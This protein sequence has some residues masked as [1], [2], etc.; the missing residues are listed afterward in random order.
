MIL[1]LINTKVYI[2]FLTLFVLSSIS[3]QNKKI[4]IHSNIDSAYVFINNQFIGYTPLN[5]IILPNDTINLLI[6]DENVLNW[7]TQKIN[8]NIIVNKDTTILIYFKHKLFINTI[9]DNAEIFLN[10]KI[11]GKSPLFILY[12]MSTSNKI[13]I[14]KENFNTVSL[15]TDSIFSKTLLIE[16]Q[17]LSIDQE[18]K[19]KKIKSNNN[20]TEYIIIGG[21]ISGIISGYSKM[22]ADHYESEYN[23]N[24]SKTNKEKVYLYDTISNISLIIFECSLISVS[25][26]LLKD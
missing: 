13:E 2:F 7:S 11:I 19:Q 22:R 24:K 21:I 5:D 20:M 6:T 17:E 8:K 3:A 10:D 14:K 9:P 16:L 23:N 1:R 18:K 4:S 12:D 26:L 15:K 25:Y